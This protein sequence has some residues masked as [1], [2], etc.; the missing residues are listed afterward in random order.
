MPGLLSERNSLEFRYSVKVELIECWTTLQ[1]KFTFNSLFGNIFKHKINQ[2]VQ[3]F[4]SFKSV[5]PVYIRNKCLFDEL[6]WQRVK[7]TLIVSRYDMLRSISY[8]IHL[9][10]DQNVGQD[11]GHD[12]HPPNISWIHDVNL[13]IGCN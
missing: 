12:L 5:K 1:F 4:L 13:F 6:F 3:L 8:D 9:G 7:P 11:L 10:Q 2:H